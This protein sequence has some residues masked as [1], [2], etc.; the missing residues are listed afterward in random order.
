MDQTSATGRAGFRDRPLITFDWEGTY[1][2]YI[3]AAD[4]NASNDTI[5]WNGHG[6]HNKALVLFQC[7]YEGRSDAGM[8]D[9]Q[10]YYVENVDSDTIKLHTTNALNTGSLVN[11]TT[12]SNTAGFNRLVLV[13][14]VEAANGTLRRTQYGQYQNM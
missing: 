10:V 12:P 14:K 1:Q 7:P 3:D 11:L 4:V 13:Y 8:N 6:M 2:K 5:T 9:G